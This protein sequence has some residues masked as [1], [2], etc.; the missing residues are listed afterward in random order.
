MG[1]H[2]ATPLATFCKYTAPIEV[3]SLDT[4]SVKEQKTLKLQ[5]NAAQTRG[6]V[7]NS[8]QLGLISPLYLVHLCA[9][10]YTET[11]T[12]LPKAHTTEMPLLPGAGRELEVDLKSTIH[13][14]GCF[15]AVSSVFI[16]STKGFQ[17][18]S[19]KKG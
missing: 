3:C 14:N 8:G 7:Q 13:C 1:R 12:A 6:T 4:A 11:H 18:P 2:A 17:T 19:I 5:K 16:H 10:V 15:S 9:C